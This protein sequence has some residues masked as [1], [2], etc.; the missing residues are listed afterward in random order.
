MCKPDCTGLYGFSLVQKCTAAL[1]CI[2]YGAPCD[3]NEDCLCM[4]EST[5]F[6][7]VGRFCRTVVAVFEKYYLQAL[8]S[9]YRM[10]PEDFLGCL[11]VS[12]ACTRLGRTAHL[13][14]RDCT[15]VTPE[16]AV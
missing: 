9:W 10:Q 4:A 7:T 13:I 8:E 5:C 16:S 3:T 11:G 1:R 14:G 12:F 2:A 15:K 6:K